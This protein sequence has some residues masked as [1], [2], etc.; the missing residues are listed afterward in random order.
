M[1]NQNDSAKIDLLQLEILQY[2]YWE[3]Y[4]FEKDIAM[5]LPI[6]HPKRIKMRE[7]TADIL[8]KIHKLKNKLKTD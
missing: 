7:Y 1:L 8:D 6:D 4:K 5:V 2:N 3:H